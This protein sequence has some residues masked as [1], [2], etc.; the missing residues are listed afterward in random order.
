MEL[1]QDKKVIGRLM[2][3][4]YDEDECNLALRGVK[5]PNCMGLEVAR[6]CVIR[7]IRHRDGF[8]TEL[9]GMFPEFTRALNARSIMSGKIP[10][11]IEPE[12][13]PY[14]IWYPDVPSEEACRRLAQAYPQMKYNIGR[15]C[16]V[17]GYSTLL[18]ELELLPDVHIAEEARDNG[19]VAIFE[20]IMSAYKRYSVMNDYDRKVD[21]KVESQASRYPHVYLNGDTATRSSLDLKQGHTAPYGELSSGFEH[22]SFNITEDYNIAAEST[23]EDELARRPDV[24]P[25]LYTPLPHDYPTNANKDVLILMAAFYGDVDRYARLRRPKYIKHE[26]ACVLRGIYHNPLFARWWSTQPK[27][28]STFRSA[29]L[30]RFIMNNDLTRITEQEPKEFDMPEQIWYP[31]V[32]KEQTYEELFRRRPSMKEQIARA[33]IVAD[34]QGLYNSLDVDAHFFLLLEAKAASNPY[35]L[36]DQER[37]AEAA[38]GS[39]ILSGSAAWKWRTRGTEFTPSSL[40]LMKNITEGGGVYTDVEGIYDD[41]NVNVGNVITNISYPEEFKKQLRLEASIDEEFYG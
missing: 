33:C 19:N 16:A 23:N 8:A 36:Q 28:L 30:A 11:M 37:K 20:A 9:R 5:I 14:C 24:S 22:N 12:E 6:L 40:T 10:E 4:K 26:M 7:G 34:Y 25:W 3:T 2:R 29:I 13:I 17:A 39:K 15:A 35:Y 31:D 41:W 32:A 21:M 38:G 27:I 18:Q 1:Q